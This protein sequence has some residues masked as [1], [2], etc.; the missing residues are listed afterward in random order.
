MAQKKMLRSNYCSSW[1]NR[2]FTQNIIPPIFANFSF[3]V[4][5]FLFHANIDVKIFCIYE[6]WSNK[7]YL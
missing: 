1:K 5:F 2:L 3:Q 7:N 6:I 4:F